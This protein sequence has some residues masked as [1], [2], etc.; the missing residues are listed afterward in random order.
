MVRWKVRPSPLSYFR[1]TGRFGER[2]FEPSCC[3]S[4]FWSGSFTVEPLAGTQPN[5]A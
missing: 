4:V 3:H 1:F 2:L 5:S